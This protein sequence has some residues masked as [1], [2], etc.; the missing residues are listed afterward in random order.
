MAD[1]GPSTDRIHLNELD[2]FKVFRD[3]LSKNENPKMNI[4]DYKDGMLYLWVGEDNLL[5]TTNLKPFGGFGGY[6]HYQVRI[7]FLLQY[8]RYNYLWLTSPTIL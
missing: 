8:S 2:M 5:L 4:I 6:G 7:L 1:M 3:R